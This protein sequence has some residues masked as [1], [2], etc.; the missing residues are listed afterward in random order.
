MKK[1]VFLYFIFG[2]FIYCQ[3]TTNNTNVSST[4]SGKN[5]LEN[6]NEVDETNS[7]NNS[8]I[9]LS[10]DT[11]LPFKEMHIENKED[12]LC[13]GLDISVNSIIFNNGE[14]MKNAFD[15][16][17]S[18]W[19]LNDRIY[20]T[21]KDSLIYISFGINYGGYAYEYKEA[22]IGYIIGSVDEFIP[23]EILNSSFNPKNDLYIPKFHFTKTKYSN[24]VSGFGIKLSITEKE[25]ENITKS[26][27]WKLSKEEIYDTTVYKYE[28][29]ECIYEAKY[30][31]KQGKLIRFSFGYITP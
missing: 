2:F 31:F 25:L 28:N 11:N 7:N 29:V 27:K 4:Q 17:D 19:G 21:T 3:T 13:K 20:F 18:V 6:N 16:Y 10:K 15:N 26:K 22:E 8:T 24:F 5:S 23:E 1:I 12:T 14:S 30:F 9:L